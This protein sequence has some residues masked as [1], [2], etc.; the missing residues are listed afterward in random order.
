MS[1]E[2]LQWKVH[3]RGLLEEISTNP[4]CA[5]LRI[6]IKILD[7]L[8]RQ[9]AKRAIEINDEKLNALMM[10][11]TLYSIADPDSPDYDGKRLSKLLMEAA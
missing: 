5:T 7:G 8:L 10:C 1:R 2:N 6:P 4:Q 3:T 9:V 11:L